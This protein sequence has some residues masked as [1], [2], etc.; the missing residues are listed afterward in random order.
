MNVN[1]VT[2]I[3][4]DYVIRIEG[5]SVVLIGSCSLIPDRY[6]SHCSDTWGPVWRIAVCLQCGCYQGFVLSLL[7]F[8]LYS[9]L[10]V[11]V[12]VCNSLSLSDPRSHSS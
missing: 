6:R 9:V 8:T 4:L 1:Y 5:G 7:S 3:D 10:L 2:L 11:T 12:I